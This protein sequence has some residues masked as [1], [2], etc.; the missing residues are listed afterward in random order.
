MTAPSAV[1]THSDGAHGERDRLLDLLRGVAVIRVAA[2][3]ILNKANFWFW[4]APTYIAPGMP[5]VFF[6][7][8]SLA[9]RSLRTAADGRR[10]AA[11]TYWRRTYRRLLLPYWVFYAV[12]AAIALAGDA[13]SDGDRWTVDPVALAWGATG[14]V[15]PNYSAEARLLTGHVWF[16]SVFLVLTLLA[17]AMVRAFE[18]R[19]WTLLATSVTTFAVLAVLELSGDFRTPLAL[20]RTAMFSILYVVGFAYTAGRIGATP[21]W[22]LAG[23]AAVAALGAWA[24]DGTESGT[25]NA[26]NVMHLLVGS[27]WLFALLALA[28]LLRRAVADRH[29]WLDAITRRSYTTYLWGWPT[30]SASARWTRG[31]LG[32]GW[33]QRLAMASMSIALL[34]V[35]IWVFGPV[36]DVAAGRRPGAG[37]GD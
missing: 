6:V 29:R 30:C 5:I 28:P 11:M 10:R 3:H 26:S 23:V 27:A 20:D 19:P 2:I 18:R 16:M 33:D 35:A 1:A 15:V 4:P 17:P 21:R 9:F 37:G 31:W 32:R 25:V 24:Y 14:L 13:I 34:L 22:A 8:G 7:S 36:E 12:I